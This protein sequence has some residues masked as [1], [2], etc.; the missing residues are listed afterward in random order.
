MTATKYTTAL[1]ALLLFAQNLH[2]QESAEIIAFQSG[3]SGS[4]N[5]FTLDPAG[6]NIT[7][8]TTSGYNVVPTISPDGSK[9]AFVSDR[10]G[11]YHIYVMNIDGSD[12]RRLSN[13]PG[14]EDGHTWSPDGSRIYFRKSV[15]GKKALCVI[16]VDGDNFRKFNIENIS[17]RSPRISPDGKKIL[18]NPNSGGHFELWV[19]NID[20]TDP[21]R[22]APSI[23]WGNEPRWSPDGSMIAYAYY[24][25][26][27]SP[28]S[29]S[30]VEIHV[31]NAD[32][33][34][35]RAVTDLGT[36]SEYPCWSP[37]G[38]KIAFQ[39]FKD[40]NFEVYTVNI[41]GTE[42]RR[43]TDSET[44]DGRPDWATVAN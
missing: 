42:L 21:H 37:D 15:E 1:V 31:C 26:E 12:Q 32:G 8:L 9:I 17:V 39:T 11:E 24:K 3:R 5:V 25:E 6:N 35:D 2:A 34:D 7:Q 30:P 41:D 27:P 19:M 33:T 13:T 36:T 14:E 29:S 16:D 40:G 38:K 44:F 22:I 18:F 20:G 23:N 10:D 4:T 28:L 43:I